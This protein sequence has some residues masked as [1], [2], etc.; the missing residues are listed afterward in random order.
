M[1]TKQKRRSWPLIERISP[2]AA[3]LLRE[4]IDTEDLKTIWML[5]EEASHQNYAGATL[6]G[7]QG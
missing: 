3:A 7:D 6:K 2:R 4:D 5:D 1:A